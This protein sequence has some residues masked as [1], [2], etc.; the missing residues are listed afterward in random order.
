MPIL[1]VGIAASLM[2]GGAFVW[3]REG[4]SWSATG[5]WR[6]ISVNDFYTQMAGHNL[7]IGSGGFNEA[8]V[9]LANIELGLFL[10][11]SGLVIFIWVRRFSDDGLL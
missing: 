2:V 1:F 3:L 5:R 4:L 7:R 6:P 10:F 11:I 9:W 8:V